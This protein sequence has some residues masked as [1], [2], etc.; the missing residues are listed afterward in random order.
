MFS[1]FSPSRPGTSAG[2]PPWG[3]QQQSAWAAMPPYNMGTRNAKKS[4]FMA[5]VTVS[6]DAFSVGKQHSFF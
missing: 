4:V 1:L 5:E 6:S 2:I 3:C